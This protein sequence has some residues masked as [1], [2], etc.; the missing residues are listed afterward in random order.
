VYRRS[1]RQ[2]R[3]GADLQRDRPTALAVC[4]ASGYAVCPAVDVAE[5]RDAV[6]LSAQMWR[7]VS[8]LGHLTPSFA[9]GWPS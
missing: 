5:V 7:G 2:G 9:L 3:P 8:D 4:L 1:E 6:R